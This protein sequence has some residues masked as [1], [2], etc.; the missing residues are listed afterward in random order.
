VYAATAHAPNHVT[1]E[2]G[3]KNN[4]VFGIPDPEFPIHYTTF[5]GLRRRLRVVCSRTV[6][7]QSRFRAKNFVP[8][9]WCP[10]WRFL[11][12][13]GVLFCDP[14]GTSLRRTASFERRPYLRQK[15][16]ARLG[17]SLAQEPPPP[18]KKIAESLCA[19]GRETT[20]AQKRNP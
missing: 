4:Y 9:K 17:G 6:Q 19:E 2:Y 18:K 8:S 16:C 3:V 7:C 10:K 20:H 14:H 13:M 12:K 5:I 15:R 11:G 1:H